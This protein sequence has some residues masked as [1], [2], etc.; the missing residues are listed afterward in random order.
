[1]FCPPGG[2]VVMKKIAAILGIVA[3]EQEPKTAVLLCNGTKENRPKINNYDGVKTCAIAHATYSGETACAYGCLG[4]GDCVSVCQEGGVKMDEETGLPCFNDEKCT[5][6]GICI[7][8]CPRNLIEL[9]NKGKNNK[10]IFVA[11]KNKDKGA[12]AKKAC[13][14]ACIGCG[15]CLKICPFDAITLN[16]N[17]AYI[18]FT[19]C[20]LCRK[21]V[22][23][24]PTKAILEINFPP[25]KDNG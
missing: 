23:E 3:E 15:K 21:C 18:D 22:A 13:S 5:S 19:K 20:K 14:S 24:C 16:N 9:R 10:R 1:M 7:K 4:F 8:K 17:C 11:C 12:D 6:C 25:R 2:N